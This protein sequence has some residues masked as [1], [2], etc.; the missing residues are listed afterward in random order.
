MTMAISATSKGIPIPNP[1]INLEWSA[2]KVI[3]NV[4][5]NMF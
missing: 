4:I 2:K 3:M 1:V 5:I